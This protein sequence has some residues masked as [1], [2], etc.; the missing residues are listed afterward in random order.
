MKLFKAGDDPGFVRFKC[1]DCFPV[2]I[3]LVLAKRLVDYLG[4]LLFL[5]DG[6]FHTLISHAKC[7][8]LNVTGV[9]LNVAGKSTLGPR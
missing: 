9:H 1:S 3:I 8:L 6:I 7:F 5:L 4:K 2:S